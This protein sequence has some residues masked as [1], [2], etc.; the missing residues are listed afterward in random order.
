MRFF[1]ISKLHLIVIKLHIKSLNEVVKVLTCMCLRSIKGNTPISEKHP[2]PFVNQCC[3]GKFFSINTGLV[4]GGSVTHGTTEMYSLFLYTFF[5]KNALRFVGWDDF[6]M[7]RQSFSSNVYIRFVPLSMIKYN[8]LS[9][10]GNQCLERVCS[11]LLLKECNI[12]VE[13]FQVLF[14][15]RVIEILIQTT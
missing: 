4:E 2:L 8:A 1:D 15:N 3:H 7:W 12:H 13:W 5:F 9:V 11:A 6:W 10:K 14:L